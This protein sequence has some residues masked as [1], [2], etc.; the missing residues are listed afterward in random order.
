MN[1]YFPAVEFIRD[2]ADDTLFPDFFWGALDLMKEWPLTAKIDWC[3]WWDYG[4]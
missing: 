1:G 4:A 2:Q 3:Y